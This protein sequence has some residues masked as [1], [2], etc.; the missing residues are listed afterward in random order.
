MIQKKQSKQ[1][2]GEEAQATEMEKRRRLAS[3]RGRQ[4]RTRNPEEG[5]L[6]RS[7]VDDI[8][9]NS[10]ACSTPGSAFASPDEPMVARPRTRSA[11]ASVHKK[12]ARNSQSRIPYQNRDG[13]PSEASTLLLV[14]QI[15]FEDNRVD[16]ANHVPV[17]AFPSK[18]PVQAKD[19][20]SQH[21]NICPDEIDEAK[22][23]MASS[24]STENQQVHGKNEL[25]LEKFTLDL[26][27]QT[28]Q[29]N[30]PFQAASPCL[31]EIMV[32]NNVPE[33]EANVV[34]NI[35]ANRPEDTANGTAQTSE[36][37]TATTSSLIMSSQNNEV[38]SVPGDPFLNFEG[39][40]VKNE[41]VPI[42][43]AIFRK[44]GDIAKE[45]SFTMESRACLLELVC[46]IYKRLEA[47]KFMQLTTLEL[48][49]MLGQIGDLELVKVDVG[50]LQKRLHQISKAR[51]MY[52]G[53]T[54][55]EDVRARSLLVI[56]EKQKAVQTCE[57]E[58]EAC[59]AA[60]VQLKEKLQQEKDELAAAQSAA[61]VINIIYDGSLV[62][63]LV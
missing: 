17:E 26:L 62:H 57:D 2:R 44:H 58:L 23:G 59:M 61:R 34:S 54:T 12:A 52:D 32:D 3:K 22:K 5:E 9:N 29:P 7:I 4:K 27:A 20:H 49:S 10:N 48:E 46:T 11:L 53:V 14:K 25:D 37:L 19:A 50:W 47:S 55:L 56:N 39:Y 31:E 30:F 43:E 45:S 28:Q 16:K 36:N 40:R 33:R 13:N 1:S 63:G 6:N 24:S 18:P 38:M 42:L 15:L 8:D 51:Q 60:V 21:E 41:V 35:F